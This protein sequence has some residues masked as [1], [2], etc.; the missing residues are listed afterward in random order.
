MVSLTLRQSL[1]V[2]LALVSDTLAKDWES[3]EYKWLYEFPLPIPPPKKERFP[4]QP[5]T[6]PVTGKKIRYYEIEIKEFTQQVYPNLGPAKLVGYDGISPGPTFLMERGEEA[7]VRFTNHAKMASSIHLHGSYSRTPW[8]GWAEDT[9]A[10]GEYKDYYYPNSQSAR[11][12]WYH[13]HAIDHTAENAYFGQAGAYLLHDPAEDGLGLP[14]GYGI[15][16]IPL[17]LSA[18]QYNKDGTLYSPANEETS[19]YGDVIH[20]N[21]QPWPY[22]KVEPR[23]YRFRLLDAAISRT[24]LLYLEDLNQNKIKFDVIS[25]DAGLL[26]GPQNVQELYISMAERYEIVVDFSNY[27]GQN[28]TLRNTRGFAPDKDYLHTDKVMRF[29]VGG[30]SVS[31]KSDVPSALRAVPFPKHKTGVDQHFLFHRQGSDWR[32]NGVIFA[33]A[34][35]RVLAKPKRGTIEVWELENSSGGGWSHPVHIHLVDFR[36]IKRVN[37]RGGVVFPYE[38][39]GLKDV[40]WV[41]PGETVTVEAHY[42][43]WPGVYMFHCHNLIH[44]D[45]EMMAAFNVSVLTDLGYEETQFADPMEGEWRAKKEDPAAYSYDAIK[46]R[47]EYMAKFQPYNRL[48]EVE[49]K[50]D[51]YWATKIIS[52]SAAT[53]ISVPS[54]L[55]V[56]TIPSSLAA[57]A[58]VKITSAVTSASLTVPT[59]ATITSKPGDDQKKDDDKKK[60]EDKKKTSTTTTLSKKKRALRFRGVNMEIPKPTAALQT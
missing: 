33:D 60:E 11:T 57:G 14:A 38:S 12:L 54:T 6:N 37:G 36:V 4:N 47:L 44:E 50:L 27:K 34:N 23:K 46:S 32:I 43:P 17:I 9:T 25:S 42:A 53:V 1:A 52:P 10:A 48:D 18:K 20:V 13:D 55:V 40:V 8:D 31:D 56:S 30:D 58:T 29:V 28:V 35:N 19:L 45:H 51:A 59:Q 22:L 21:G 24:F 15:Y 39:Q 3:P 49:K 41:G 26:T 5:I 7:V 16:D 2:V